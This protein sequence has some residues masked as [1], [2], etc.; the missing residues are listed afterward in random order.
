MKRRIVISVILFVSIFVVTSANLYAAAA[1]NTLKFTDTYAQKVLCSKS[2]GYCDVFDSGKFTI[3]AKLSFAGVDISKFNVDTPFSIYI[4]NFYY[5]GILGDAI[6][7][8]GSLNLTK[9]TAKIIVKSDP[10]WDIYK[11]TYQY[12][13]I[14]LKWNAKQFQATITGI[15]PTYEV[16]IWAD[17]HLYETASINEEIDGYIEFGENVKVLFDS[18]YVKGKA[19]VKSIKKSGELF[20]VSTI[21][22]T[23]TG[24][25]IPFVP[26]TF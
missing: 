6:G 26:E 16:P 25:G 1:A 22:L 20:D 23:G 13:Q 7:N 19:T 14:Q 17:Y 2:A 9:G 4:G 24:N 5:S 3:T 15:T 21:K 10:E 8:G 18:I 12:L 11:R